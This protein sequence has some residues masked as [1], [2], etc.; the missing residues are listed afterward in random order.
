MKFMNGTAQRQ[1]I[2]STIPADYASRLHGTRVPAMPTH[3]HSL[4]SAY[5]TCAHN[6]QSQE[7]E[8]RK[9]RFRSMHHV[10][11]LR[12]TLLAYIV[13]E[14]WSWVVP[15]G[16]YPPIVSWYWFNAIQNSF[17]IHTIWS[18]KRGQFP[19]SVRFD[20]YVIFQWFPSRKSTPRRCSN[21]S[22]HLCMPFRNHCDSVSQTGATCM[23]QIKQPND[24]I[25]NDFNGLFEHGF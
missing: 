18:R 11:S 5:I 7:I 6:R 22:L 8:K 9:S 14:L 24:G 20:I 13:C 4:S 15:T 17:K 19:D 16:C 3:S 21:I 23:I 25:I 10:N 2:L 12:W 1:K